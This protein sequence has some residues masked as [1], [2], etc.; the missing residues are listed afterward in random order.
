MTLRVPIARNKACYEA[1]N[2]AVCGAPYGKVTG[3]ATQ[4]PYKLIGKKLNVPGTFWPDHTKEEKAK[5]WRV[6]IKDYV[7]RFPWDKGRQGV[8]APAYLVE[9]GGFVYPMNV[10]MISK[11]LPRGSI[12]DHQESDDELPRRTNQPDSDDPEQEAAP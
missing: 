1:C 3:E 7:A 9:Q 2:A 6:S 8:A 4:D 10:S 5:C 11:L 12:Q